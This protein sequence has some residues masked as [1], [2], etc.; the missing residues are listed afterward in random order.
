MGAIEQV[1]KQ[2]ESDGRSTP[3]ISYAQRPKGTAGASQ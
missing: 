2:V 3:I 1:G